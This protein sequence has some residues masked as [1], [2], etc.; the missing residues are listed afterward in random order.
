[1]QR[2]VWWRA[3]ALMLPVTLVWFGCG[4]DDDDDGGTPDTNAPPAAVVLSSGA[5]VI[6]SGAV[7]TVSPI[8][9]P[10][11]GRLTATVTWGTPDVMTAYFRKGGM[12][13]YGWVNGSSP[14]TST[15][16]GVSGGDSFT[17]YIYNPGASSV[18]VEWTV[19]FDPD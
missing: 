2:R 8:E 16:N 17:F 3:V 11:E 12:A 18:N 6:G 15:V 14:L 9:P 10:A 13:Y 1:M 7:K 4:C 19:R 5:A